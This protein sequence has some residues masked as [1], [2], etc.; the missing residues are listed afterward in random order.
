[1]KDNGLQPERSFLSLERSF[2]SY[3]IIN[4]TFLK[5][6]INKS[7]SF[8]YI[9]IFLMTIINFYYITIL[10]NFK[11]NTTLRKKRNS[12]TYRLILLSSCVFNIILSTFLILINYL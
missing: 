5:I 10:I 12:L 8:F 2:F 11:K 7:F 9:S 3:I 1:M 6:L 4:F